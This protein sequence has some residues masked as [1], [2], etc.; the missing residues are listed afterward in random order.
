MLFFNE[1]EENKI[2]ARKTTVT[3]ANIIVCV[4][5]FVN[6]NLVSEVG[7]NSKRTT[8]YSVVLLF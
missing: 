8:D 2:F 1:Q 5:I 3:V 4:K 7:T 6:K